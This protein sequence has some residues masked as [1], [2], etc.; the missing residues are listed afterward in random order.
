M[1]G[2]TKNGKKKGS[3]G[4]GGKRKVSLAKTKKKEEDRKELQTRQG[5]AREEGEFPRVEMTPLRKERGE[6]RQHS[7]TQLSHSP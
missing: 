5:C 3:E 4:K 6:Q 1:K 2:E 7:S